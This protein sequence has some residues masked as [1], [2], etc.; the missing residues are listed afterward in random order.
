MKNYLNYCLITILG[1]VLFLSSCDRVENP[2]VVRD[3]SL[4]WSLYPN[5]D[6]TTYPW[7]TWTANANTTLNVMLEDYTG[8]TCTNCPAA[9]VIAKNIEDSKGGKV[10]V[11]SV[12]ASTTSGFQLPEPPELPLDHR[13]EAGTEY[14]TAMGLT[15]NPAGMVNRNIYSSNYY[16]FDSEWSGYVDAELT[17]SPDFNIQVQFNHYPST[18]GLFI[19]TEVEALNAVS[20]DYNVIVMLVREHVEAP[21]K[22]T[23]GVINEEY[24]HHNVLSDNINDTWGTP[25]ITGGI[26]AGEKI[27]NNYTY[28]LPDP[29]SDTTYNVNNLSLVTVVSDRNTYQIKQVV[30]TEL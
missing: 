25:I 29:I 16:T 21:Q 17:N 6:T 27:Y 24:E 26:G 14:A 8:H 9:A 3:T 5:S 18:N 22:E 15:F 20:S 2:L 10:T 7:P 1:T 30:K 11:V 28:Q 4:N 19:H 12:H 13:T 23:G